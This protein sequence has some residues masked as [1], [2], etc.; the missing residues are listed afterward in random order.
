MAESTA[1]TVDELI[2]ELSLASNQPIGAGNRNLYIATAAANSI[3]G[4]IKDMDV[5]QLRTY[6]W[7]VPPLLEVLIIDADHPL[8]TKAA[9]VLRGLMP[10]RICISRLIECQGLKYIAQVLDILLARNL[11]DMKV[12]CTPRSIV[13]NLVVCYREVARYYPWDV[14]NARAIRHGVLLLKYGDV[15]IQT[16]M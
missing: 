2:L 9:L 7:T 3:Y 4:R 6:E 12:P 13:E 1:V 5:K 15:T 11:S 14:V 10:S 8:T 16:I